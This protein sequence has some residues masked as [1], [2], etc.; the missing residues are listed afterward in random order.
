[1]APALIGAEVPVSLLSLVVAA[2]VKPHPAATAD[3][4]PP[5]PPPA[6]ERRARADEPDAPGLADEPPVYGFGMTALGT[7]D[8]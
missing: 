7:A 8:P 2:L 4:R 3:A 5:D 1:V 6:Q